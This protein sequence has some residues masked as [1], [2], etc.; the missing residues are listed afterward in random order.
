MGYRVQNILEL[1][2]TVSVEYSGG[3]PLY[4]GEAEPGTLKGKNGWRIKKMSYSGTDVTDVQWADGTN[5]MDK[6]WDA[7]A[8]YTYS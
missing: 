5:M 3:Q 2:F 8:S 1:P 6:V 7:R 4:V